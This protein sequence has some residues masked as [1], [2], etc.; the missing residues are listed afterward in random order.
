MVL[1]VV[2]VVAV[3]MMEQPM[4]LA[5]PQLKANLAGSLAL[6]VMEGVGW[7]VAVVAAQVV[8]LLAVTYQVLVLEKLG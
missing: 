3:G 4:V 5:V 7:Q 6:V 1:M 2:L 8:M